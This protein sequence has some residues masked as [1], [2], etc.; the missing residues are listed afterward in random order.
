MV[1]RVM[2]G[3]HWLRRLLVTFL[4]RVFYKQVY[5][6]EVATSQYG[7]LAHSRRCTPTPAHVYLSNA[8]QCQIFFFPP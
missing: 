5:V 4:D 2:E 6:S 8:H 1:M 7:K 3:S